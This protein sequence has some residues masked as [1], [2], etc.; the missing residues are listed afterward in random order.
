MDKLKSLYSKIVQLTSYRKLLSEG[1]RMHKLWNYLNKKGQGIVEYAVLLAF[2]VGLAMMLNGADISGTVKKTFD[3][4]AVTLGAVRDYAS[5]IK[6]WS[7]LSKADILKED[8]DKRIS[9]DQEALANIGEFFIGMHINDVKGLLGDACT[10]R[11]TLV[12]IGEN[13]AELMGEGNTRGDGLSYVVER[14]ADLTHK[15]NASATKEDVIHWMQHDYGTV[16]SEGNRTYDTNY[17]Y[18]SGN[19]YF[20]SDYA[21]T[22]LANGENGKTEPYYGNGVKLK[23]TYENSRVKAAEVEIDHDQIQQTHKELSMT[24]SKDANGNIVRKATYN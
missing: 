15:D 1:N 3:N 8:K 18:D 20:F 22:N 14:T 11:Q 7:G 19:R 4:V 16:D 5:A 9:V 21:V 23:L 6:N 2:I 10:S 24:V 17:D 13:D 12:H